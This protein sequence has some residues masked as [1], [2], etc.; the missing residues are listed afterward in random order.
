VIRRRPRDQAA[1]EPGEL[2]CRIAQNGETGEWQ[3]EDCDGMP[4]TV[5]KAGN[6]NARNPARPERER[7]SGP[8][9]N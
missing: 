6:G 8:G 4:L 5:T 7:R 2:L 3:A 1:G 9:S